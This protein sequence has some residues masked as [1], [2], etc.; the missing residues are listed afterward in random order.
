MRKLVYSGN[1][2]LDGYIEDADGNFDWTEPDEEV[3]RF[4]NEWVREAGAALMGRGTYETMEPYWTDVAANPQ[5]P[6]YA[7]EFAKVWVETP[8][9]VVS[10][11][12]ES[13]PEGIT[14]ITDLEREVAELK[15]APGGP[16]DAGGAALGNSL[17]ELD[18]VDELMIVVSPVALGA[19]KANLG[20][21]FAGKYWKP[22]EQKQFISGAVLLR[23]ERVRS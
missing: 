11:S 12:L 3:H 7:D 19:G 15:E 18:L 10:S 22:L 23:Y 4:W 1:T 13:V 14:L 20:P 8:R 16:I 2:S 21:A 17:A 9:Y 5:G 6:D